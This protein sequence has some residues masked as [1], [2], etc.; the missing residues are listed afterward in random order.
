M[1]R[2]CATLL[3]FAVCS[4]VVHADVTIVQKTTIEGGMAAMTGGS[5][6]PTITSKIKGMKARMDMDMQN[7][8]MPL[9]ISTI[10]DVT[11]KQVII[12]NHSQKTAQTVSATTPP[13][14]ATPP[15]MTAKVDASVTP[16]GKSQVIDGYKC[17]EYS[18]T[19]TLS[20]A[21][22]GGGAMPPEAAAAMKDVTMVMKGSMWVT[23]DAPG[24]AEYRAFGK[25][26]A[27][28]QLT[29]NAVM[30]STGMSMPGM[31]KLQKA[32]AAADGVPYLTEM[33][34]TFEGTGQMV[35]MM[36][37]M[38]AM[39]IIQRVTSINTDTIGDDQFKTPE[40]YSVVKQDK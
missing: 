25:A 17:E 2:W 12:L 4:A 35:E 37:Q 34:M 38:G 33:N 27:D 8:A 26:M 18:F 14:G 19:T 15:S 10:T 30:A 36:R 16:T 39:K 28:A 7:P 20:M 22:V 32:M 40:G 21:E 1:K 31:D 23:K 9:S 24:L 5:P 13:A 6:T 29:T 11:A 3:V